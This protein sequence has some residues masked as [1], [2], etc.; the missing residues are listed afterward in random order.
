MGQKRNNIPPKTSFLQ[1]PPELRLRIY[2]EALICPNDYVDKPMIVIQDRGNVFTTRGKYRAM[3][4]CPSWQGDDGT[5]RKLLGL[6]HQIHDETED[7]LYSQHTLFF[8]NS[9]DL[10]RIGQFLDTLSRTA[11]HR[12]RSVGFEIFFFVHAEPGVPKRTMKQY[13]RASKILAERLPRWKS[14]FFYLDPRFYYPS[15]QAGGG[16]GKGPARGV[17]DLAT[18]FGV[19]C[20][21]VTF[22]PLPE[23]DHHLLEEAQQI[24]WRSSSPD[25]RAPGESRRSMKCSSQDPNED[26]LE[27]YFASMSIHHRPIHL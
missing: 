24:V 14:V 6:N 22:S 21:D 23:S 25:R 5:A 15:T 4:M 12:I 10:D 19:V 8:R 17:L 27:G 18:R 7:F 16:K 3:S 20:N 9:F 26:D 2:E 11:R 13:A 1:L